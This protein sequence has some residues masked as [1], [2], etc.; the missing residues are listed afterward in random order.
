M[1]TWRTFAGVCW[2]GKR[3]DFDGD[4]QEILGRWTDCHSQCAHW[5]RN[6]TVFCKECGTRPTRAGPYGW[7][8][9]AQYKAGRGVGDAAPYEWEGGYGLPHQ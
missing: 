8:Q 6:D 5:L 4:A 1:R 2:T 9:E 3:F 7:T